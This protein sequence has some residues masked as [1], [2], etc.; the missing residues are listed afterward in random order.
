MSLIAFI[1]FVLCCFNLFCRYLSK[2]DAKKM[3]KIEP[4][5]TRTLARPVPEVARPC[6]TMP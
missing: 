6:L 5:M 4:R 1:L 2:Y 3:N